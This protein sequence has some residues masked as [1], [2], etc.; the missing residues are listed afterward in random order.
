MQTADRLLEESVQKYEQLLQTQEFASDRVEILKQKDESLAQVEANIE[1][2][3]DAINSDGLVGSG[4]WLMEM[5]DDALRVAKANT[6]FLKLF[7]AN[8]KI[9]NGSLQ[10][11]QDGMNGGKYHGTIS[12]GAYRLQIWTYNKTYIDVETKVRTKYL[13]PAS[14]IIKAPGCRLDLSWGNCPMIIPPSQRVVPFIPPR[15]R[16]TGMGG[17]DMITN[18]WTDPQA[19]NLFGGISARPLAIPTAIDRFGCLDTGL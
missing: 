13:D 4:E 3:C 5:G 6:A 14:V 17:M 19:E 12:V 1:S 9:D 11:P 15:I 7:D 18:V 2:L 16:Q 8:T 10:I